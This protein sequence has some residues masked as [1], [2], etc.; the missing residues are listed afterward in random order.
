LDTAY[1]A[2]PGFKIGDR[3]S[4]PDT[5]DQ[6]GFVDIP[7]LHDG[8]IWTDKSVDVGLG[9]DDFIITLSALSQSFPV[10]K[11]YSI[12][13]DTVFIIDVSG[14][15]TTID[16]GAGSSRISLLVDALNEAIGI[17]QDA[18]PFNRVAVVAYGGDLGGYA[19][20]ERV[21]ALG[22]YNAPGGGLFSVADTTV[23]V[24]ATA[25]SASGGDCIVSSFQVAGSTPTQWGIYEGA[26]ILIKR[27]PTD[28][29]VAVPTTDDSGN[30]DGEVT[31]KRRPNIIL[32]TDGEPTMGWGDYEFSGV[33]PVTP[34]PGG[35]LLGSAQGTFYGD[36]SNGEM[37]LSLLTVLTAAHRKQLVHDN[38]FPLDWEDEVINSSIPAAPDQPEAS[39]G[40]YTIGLGEQTLNAMKLINATM[41]PYGTDLPT[42]AGTTNAG[43][44]F[45]PA[46]KFLGAGADPNP[47]GVSMEKLLNDFVGGSAAFYTQYR[48]AWNN[49][50]WSLP[51]SKVT[52]DNAIPLTDLDYVTNLSSGGDK[53]FFTA[54][55]LQTLRDA[56][57]SITASIQSQSIS[58]VTDVGPRGLADFDGY[59]TFSDVLGEYMKFQGITGLWFDN[60]AVSAGTGAGFGAALAAN[61]PLGLSAPFAD[62]ARDAFE[63]I[64]LNHL[65]YGDDVP[66]IDT[67][68]VKQLIQSNIDAGYVQA[69]NSIKYYADENRHFMG[70]FFDIGGAEALIPDGAVAV[71]EIFPMMGSVDCLVEG[72]PKPLMLVPFHVITVLED[73]T[74]TEI[75]SGISSM[76]PMKRDLKAGDQM[77]RWYIP[78]DLIPMREVDDTGNVTGNTHPIRI[79]YKVGLDMARIEAGISPEYQA[80]NM[81]GNNLYFYSNRNDPDTKNDVTLAFYQPHAENPYYYHG[82]LPNQADIDRGMIKTANPTNTAPHVVLARHDT[83]LFGRDRSGARVERTDLHWL[84]NNGLLTLTLDTSPPPNPPPPPQPP[85]LGSLIITKSFE[86]LPDN[87]NVFDDLSPITFLVVGRDGA[88]KEIFRQTVDFNAENFIWNPARGRYEFTLTD[89]PLGDYFIYEK[90]GHADGFVFTLPGLRDPVAT[91]ITTSGAQATVNF[92]NRYR[93]VPPP[94]PPALTVRKVFHGL[95]NDEIPDYFR[96]L[97]TGPGGFEKVLDLGQSLNGYTFEKLI[98]GEY[99]IDEINHIWPGI[100]PPEITINNQ[101]VTMPYTFTIVAD[102]YIIITA[103][104]YYSPPFVPPPIVPPLAPP[105]PTEPPDEPPTPPDV[106]PYPPDVPPNPPAPQTGDN[107]QP[108]LYIITLIIGIGLMGSVIVY[109][110]RDKMH[111]VKH[112]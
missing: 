53:G 13:A 5:S 9:K 11:G 106:P 51:N 36:G 29:I 46:P 78:A 48:N 24:N 42:E 103:D 73:A 21:L 112:R 70:S 60:D 72:I 67:A 34:G 105:P 104:N 14:S 3:V 63:N 68:Q 47:T 83:S 94:E 41:N 4:D 87:M 50:T 20:V 74:F 90:G 77:I 45:P 40:F 39:V 25:V 58:T 86:G 62:G 23:T 110:W 59:L 56:F 2:T 71:V 96:I 80:A 10:T 79:R 38:Y 76:P 52:V 28:T 49:Y 43:A 61:Q 97:I 26:E 66:T 22:R 107:R 55:D 88:G 27:A 30:P 95:T 89:L 111:F 108:A 75:F 54:A 37:G 17:L 102:T 16:P 18:N 8:R 7:R 32:M 109:W 57:T 6:T 1:A 91:S 31:V 69:N 93:P 33:N 99:T 44:V 100:N 15:M 101:Q 12:P 81:E 35:N 65:T 64:L 85:P 98:P 84:G 19:R 92:T 82:G